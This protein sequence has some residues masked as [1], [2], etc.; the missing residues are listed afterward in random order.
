MFLSGSGKINYTYKHRQFI[1]IIGFALESFLLVLLRG[2]AKIVSKALV[3][4][5]VYKAL[6]VFMSRCYVTG[7]LLFSPYQN[8]HMSV[9]IRKSA[10]TVIACVLN[11]NAVSWQTRKN[12]KL[13]KCELR[14]NA[15]N[16]QCLLKV[17]LIED[18]VSFL[19]TI[20]FRIRVVS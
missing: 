20:K 13:P 11:K 15:K 16:L 3:P 5:A 19:M 18:N 6:R 8:Y 17:G 10:S 9:S 7:I 12:G 2:N 1:V 4:P 14:Q